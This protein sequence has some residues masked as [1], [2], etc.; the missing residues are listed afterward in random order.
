MEFCVR[1]RTAH[2]PPPL[3][4]FSTRQQLSPGGT[5]KVM[6]MMM[7]RKL[8]VSYYGIEYA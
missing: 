1:T 7:G 6:M 2:T 8:P 5:V 3:V 4:N